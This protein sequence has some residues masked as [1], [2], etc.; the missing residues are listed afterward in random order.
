MKPRSLAY[1][2]LAFA[3][4]ILAGPLLSQSTEFRERLATAAMLAYGR[5]PSAFDLAH[6]AKGHET[7]EALVK[8]NG[9]QLQKDPAAQ[10]EVAVR[11]WQD[12]YGRSPAG[13]EADLRSPGATYT[14][15]LQ[16]HIVG[17]AA[18]PAEYRQV[19]D[20]AYQAVV[21]RPAYPEEHAYW[22]PRGTLPYVVLVGAIE[23]WAQRNQPGLMVTTGTPSI[24]VNSRFL[25]TLR[26]SLPV[27][28]EARAL[29]G[30][31][32]WTDVGRQ[33]SP[34]NH[35][36]AVGAADIASVGGVHFLL[37]GGGPLAGR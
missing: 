15:L 27:A 30:L 18:H 28:N 24:S 25:T 6:A 17:L 29:L 10:R 34:G 13:A 37:A 2:A 36:V 9:A 5:P 31:P 14:D 21:R 35:V 11:A 8:G 3:F 22:Q 33:H 26:L 1:S 23:N 16:Q 32:V 20:R 12:A 4:L 19:I 7:M